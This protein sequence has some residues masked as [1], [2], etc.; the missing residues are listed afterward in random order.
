M[1]KTIRELLHTGAGGD[2]AITAPA[3]EPLTFDDKASAAD[4]RML[5]RPT[6]DKTLKDRQAGRA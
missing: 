2:V 3:R 6:V 5:D 1:P 4:K